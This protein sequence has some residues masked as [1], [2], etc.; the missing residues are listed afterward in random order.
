METFKRLWELLPHIKSPSGD[1]TT[2]RWFAKNLDGSERWGGY[3]D[4]VEELWN[5][6]V[7][8]P[9][10]HF[11]V[12]PNPTFRRTGVRHSTQDVSHWSFFLIDVD[13]VSKYG[14]RPEILMNR[15]LKK[16][17]EWLSVDF[18]AHKP[19]IIDSGRGQQAWIRLDDMPL[20]YHCQYIGDRHDAMQH[21]VE[22]RRTMRYWLERLSTEFGEVCGCRIDTTTSDLPRP[23]RCPG[24]INVKNGQPAKFISDAHSVYP[25][26]TNRLLNAVPPDYAVI[27]RPSVRAD[28]EWQDVF[29]QLTIKAQK[30]LLS[31]KVEPGRHETMWHTAR[32]LAENGL[33]RD[34]TRRALIYGN[35]RRGEDNALKPED[36]EHAIDTAYKNLTTDTSSGILDDPTPTTEA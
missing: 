20:D 5:A 11:Y 31:G 19:I 24:T 33:S 25:A 8:S 3:A 26:L 18:N 23:M 13:P 22:V 7:N 32:S 9:D 1:T 10:K 21:R 2:V 6:Y 29:H 36:I 4:S 12:C 34:A 30:Y 14:P 17:G 15:A 27:N 35:T 16:F 28:A